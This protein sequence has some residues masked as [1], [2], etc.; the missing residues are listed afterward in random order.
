MLVVN[1]VSNVMM[2]FALLANYEDAVI[3]TYPLLT[4]SSTFL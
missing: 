3:P 2:D 4:R 1:P